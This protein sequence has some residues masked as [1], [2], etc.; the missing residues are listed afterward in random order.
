MKHHQS[1]LEHFCGRERE[2][3]QLVDAWR[4][5]P[6][7]HGGI[8]LVSG[9]PGIGKTSFCY[10]LLEELPRAG[11]FPLALKYRLTGVEDVDQVSA[12]LLSQ[13]VLQRPNDN[14]GEGLSPLQ[15][16]VLSMHLPGAGAAVPAGETDQRTVAA[17]W[18]QCLLNIGRRE[19]FGAV[20]YIDDLH[21]ASGQLWEH[22][23]E[24][25]RRALVEQVPLWVWAGLRRTDETADAIRLADD[26]MASLREQ[27]GFSPGPPYGVFDLRLQSLTERETG[28]VLDRYFGGGFSAGFPDCGRWLWE[29]SAGNPFYLELLIRAC[30]GQGLVARN[31]DGA[32][33][34]RSGRSGT[35]LGA[36]DDLIARRVME[37]L[38][39][40]AL[41][42]PLRMAVALGDSFLFDD[43]Q[44][45]IG[46][47]R[48]DAID[49]LL[50]LQRRGILTDFLAGDEHRVQFAHPL[51]LEAFRGLLPQDEQ[52][53][54][55]A[56]VAAF[57]GSTDRTV[58]ATDHLIVARAPLTALAPVLRRSLPAAFAQKQPVRILE[59][60]EK[61]GGLERPDQAL[62]HLYAMKS[63]SS[64]GKL[65]EAVRF[66]DL[67]DAVR[68]A[69]TPDQDCESRTI[70]SRALAA[71]DPDRAM[72][73]IE[74][75][76]ALAGADDRG[77]DKVRKELWLHKY[78]LLH[79]M[80]Q[81]REAIDLSRELLALGA[82]DEEF[83]FKVN[84][85][86]GLIYFYQ[87]RWEEADRLFRDTVVPY[88]RRCPEG[89]L[90]QVLENWGAVLA[91]LCRFSEAERQ[92]DQALSIA[93]RHLQ[94]ANI[95]SVLNS[96]G[97]V[98]MR[99]GRYD[100]AL[101]D[102][103]RAA[104]IAY[105]LD[106][107][108]LLASCLNDIAGIKMELGRPDGVLELLHRSL[109][110]KE[111]LGNRVGCATTG[112]NIAMCH[113]R[114]IGTPVDYAQALEWGLRSNAI[115]TELN[116]TVNLVDNLAAISQAHLG[117]NQLQSALE[118]AE[119]ALAAAE[120]QPT[121]Y[122]RATALAQKGTVLRALG[123]PGAGEVLSRAAE[124]FGGID[125]R[126]EQANALLQ[127]AEH[128]LAEGR[129][130][131]ARN[132]LL[133]VRGIYRELK[134]DKA[135]AALA[136]RF[137]GIIG[138]DT[139]GVAAPRAAGPGCGLRIQTLGPFR[140]WPAGA[141]RPLSDTQWGSQLGRKIMAYLLT[142]GYAGRGGIPRD[143][144]LHE[145]WG[146]GTAGGSLRVI[147]HRLRRSV[148]CPDAILFD[149]DG[150]RFNWDL[151]GIRFDREQLDALHRKG[152]ALATEGR[153]E[154]AREE[155]ERAEALFHGDYLEGF[156]EPW[157]IRTRRT[158]RSSRRAIL[159]KLV[160]LCTELERPDAAA[161]YR[162]ILSKVRT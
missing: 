55:H 37:G 137:P 102:K 106:N 138:A 132:A 53:S 44:R 108:V 81:Y 141:D 17:V 21:L 75:G 107:Q 142:E 29:R 58:Q 112:T 84:N 19:D 95:A 74:E 61:I 52:C 122:N 10:K 94:A 145:F 24:L 162:D 113:L 89:V 151:S 152:M 30:V 1:G 104:A 159:G 161:F 157:A 127:L 117:L 114:G 32:W 111:S 133:A 91:R 92:F 33:T 143:K 64:L 14:L 148:S 31:D 129:E 72:A 90:G 54:S 82:A 85:T 100:K 98:S 7:P 23:A 69:L 156:D 99:Q 87:G 93:E 116:Y 15:Q 130:E 28:Q 35:E 49:I 144:L 83:A 131:A 60:T 22:L 13:A 2:L 11:I 62:L 47:P 154:E 50:A 158:L 39:E 149:G 109:R 56:D 88:A 126:H 16:T 96:R 153:R 20:V 40:P 78:Y 18:R 125:N 26:L 101:A 150:Y 105:T 86:L 42:R 160:E 43:W 71:T 128:L 65:N 123:S 4:A 121:P 76:L 140:V 70:A 115:L 27:A 5:A 45:L 79:D 136:D 134:L 139:P 118:Y 124:L 12:S 41:A 73:V 34:Y 80:R 9:P 77:R 3:G 135:L 57:F 38:A 146:R 147:L 66:Y 120:R 67:L 155:L 48:A 6:R 8:C 46:Q 103:E 25:C 110:W 36:I 68:E 119:Q 59:W 51:L 97:S 63:A